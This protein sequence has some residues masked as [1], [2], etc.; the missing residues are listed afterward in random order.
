MN[1][2]TTSV[3]WL[4][5]M[6]CFQVAA[7][8]L[9]VVDGLF[10]GDDWLRWI[11][12]AITVAVIV[13]LFY[14]GSKK[15]GYQLSAIFRAAGLGCTLANLLLSAIVFPNGT[16]AQWLSVWATVVSVLTLLLSWAAAF[17]E[18]RAHGQFVQAKDPRLAKGWMILLVI[19]LTFAVVSTAL[20]Y[21]VTLLQDTLK[22]DY[23]M[24]NSVG[25]GMQLCNHVLTL[26]YLWFLYRTIQNCK[27]TEGA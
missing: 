17:M 8:V 22:W 27:E 6:F 24:L 26:L 11:S 23:A 20:S 2:K 25:K 21:S 18:Y 9:S 1:E 7:L 15:R 10:T 13:C 12:R 19:H 5:L 4:T 3:K 14:L 16:P